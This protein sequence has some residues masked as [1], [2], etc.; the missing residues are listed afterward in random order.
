[1]TTM[2][3]PVDKGSA[4]QA[5]ATLWRKQ[6]LPLGTIDYKGRRINFDR[7][8]LAGLVKAFR[9]KAYDQ[10]PFQLAPHDNA[11]SNDPERF[12]GEIRDFEL[13]AD[14]LDL[15]LSAT[16]DGDKVLRENPNLGVSAR[17]VEDLAR[18]DGKFFPAAVQ[19]VLGTLDPR[20]TGMRPWQAVALA[21]GDEDDEVIDLTVMEYATT[22]DEA[23]PPAAPATAPQAAQKEAGMAFTADQEARLAKLLA[24]PEDKFDAILD[25]KAAAEPET[26]EDD[27]E[28]DDG[29]PDLTEAELAAML[30]EIDAE[31]AA[32]DG[33]AESAAEPALAGASL[34]NEQQTALELANAQAA[35]AQQSVRRMQRQLDQ[36]TYEKERDSY[37]RQGIPA[38]LVDLARPLLEGSGRTVELANG[39]ST[40]AGPIVRKL[41][42]EFANTMSALGLDIELGNSQGAIEDERTKAEQDSNLRMERVSAYRQQYGL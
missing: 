13:T 35:E 5:G 12:R 10:V 32:A 17:I 40:D 16:P 11:H 7:E 4:R 41:F 28:G 22:E 6:L 25:P 1:M 42:T 20:L 21:N 24:L 26:D 39:K 27:T 29:E 2:L 9:A 8:Y 31:S 18:A 33:A 34:S 14:G 37:V 38:R 15:I 30:E 36:A 3:T 23:P 19:H